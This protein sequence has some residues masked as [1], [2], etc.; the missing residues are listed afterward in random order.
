MMSCRII[1]C[2]RSSDMQTHLYNLHV[3]RFDLHKLAFPSQVN[4][5]HDILNWRL[6]TCFLLSSLFC[7]GKMGCPNIIRTDH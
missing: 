2:I 1:V 6:S 7:R 3:C 5:S 4:K